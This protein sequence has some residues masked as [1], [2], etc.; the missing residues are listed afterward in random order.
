MGLSTGLKAES[1]ESDPSSSCMRDTSPYLG[2][3]GCRQS[4]FQSKEKPVPL[5]AT[6]AISYHALNLKN[7]FGRLLQKFMIIK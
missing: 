5:G 7:R 1:L 6:Q 4:R 3:V 2:G